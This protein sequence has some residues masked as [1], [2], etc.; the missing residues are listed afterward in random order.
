MKNLAIIFLMLFAWQG[1][2][3]SQEPVKSTPETKSAKTEPSPAP[4]V[5]PTAKRIKPFV[6]TEKQT[7][8]ITTESHTFTVEE[9]NQLAAGQPTNAETG[10]LF[11][12]GA[13]VFKTKNFSFPLSGGGASGCFNVSPERNL[14]I[15]KAVRIRFEKEKN[16]T[17]KKK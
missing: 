6:L 15:Q 13:F 14:E 3:A 9:L 1:K 4:V 5:L 12:N 7:L 2:P 8:K 11:E 17:E 10:L 16:E